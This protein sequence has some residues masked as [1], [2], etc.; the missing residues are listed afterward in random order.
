M[1][2]PYNLILLC[3]E[4]DEWLA[5]YRNPQ[6]IPDDPLYPFPDNKLQ[7]VLDKVYWTLFGFN[8]IAYGS[9]FFVAAFIVYLVFWY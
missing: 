7:R 1:R 2:P 6:E 4:Y 3:K 9:L 8:L 5:M